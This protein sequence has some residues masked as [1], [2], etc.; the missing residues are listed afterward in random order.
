MDAAR[1]QVLVLLLTGLALALCF[2]LYLARLIVVPLRR[3]ARVLR[4]VADKDLSQHA[5][6]HSRDEV[7]QMADALQDA[8]IS[9]R[10]T[11]Q[12]M[13]SNAQVLAAAS[14][15]LTGTSQQVTTSAGHAAAQVGTLSTAAE[16]VSHNTQAVSVGAEEMSASIR[17]IA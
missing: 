11:I 14:E 16:Q 6:V 8:T 17:E 3:A 2:A 13:S 4:A 1:L 10:A 5:D 7:G 9:L 15:E 12:T